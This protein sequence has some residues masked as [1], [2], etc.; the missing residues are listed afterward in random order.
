MARQRP[1]YIGP[2]CPRGGELR[3]TKRGHKRLRV[4][5][6][7]MAEFGDQIVPEYYW[8]FDYLI[9]IDMGQ[10]PFPW[11][12]VHCE[13]LSGGGDGRIRASLDS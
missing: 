8:S 10:D 12:R 11:F 9:E 2:V 7:C 4:W 1:N 3:V 5:C 6:T 13:S